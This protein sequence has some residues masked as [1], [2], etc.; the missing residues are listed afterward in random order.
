M[1][2]FLD[3]AWGGD[4]KERI[5][6]LLS[7]NTPL[8]RHFK[9]LCTGGKGPTYAHTKIFE[10]KGEGQPSEAIWGGDYQNNNGTGGAAVLPGLNENHPKY[11][12]KE[13]RGAVGS[14]HGKPNAEMAKFFII[15]GPGSSLPKKNIFGKV[16]EGFDTLDGAAERLR[17]G[18]KDVEIIDCGVALPL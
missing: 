15:T 5:H 8:A 7:P 12:R 3:L 16:Q 13:E 10:I 18:F 6:I 2:T 4:F 14:F 17:K 11:E 1:E 9:L